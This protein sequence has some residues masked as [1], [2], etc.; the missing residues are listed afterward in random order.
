MT[1]TGLQLSTPLTHRI[2]RIEVSA[3]MAVAAEA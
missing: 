2:Q 3:T 1:T